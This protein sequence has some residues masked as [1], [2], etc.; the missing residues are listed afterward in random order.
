MT[1]KKS[2]YRYFTEEEKERQRR[3]VREYE[4]RNDRINIIFPAGT[5]DRIKALHLQK[6][7]SAFIKDTILAELDRLEKILN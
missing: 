1:E 7:D 3:Y 2:N 5:R 4:K 6:S